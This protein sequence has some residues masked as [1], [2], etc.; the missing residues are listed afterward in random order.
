MLFNLK[1]C[2]NSKIHRKN[3]IGH[4]QILPKTIFEFLI[5]TIIVNK[6]E[7]AIIVAKC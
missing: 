2:I 3:G 1:N 7:Y 6:M 4:K 5:F